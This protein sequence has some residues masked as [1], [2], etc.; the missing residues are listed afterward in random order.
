MNALD[1]TLK[2]E[3][4]YTEVYRVDIGSDVFIGTCPTVNE[5]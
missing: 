4:P 3:G 2:E 5:H 1:G